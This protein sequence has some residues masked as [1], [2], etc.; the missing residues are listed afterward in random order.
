MTDLTAIAERFRPHERLA[1]HLLGRLPSH[2]DGAHGPAHLLRVWN[3]VRRIQPS[4]GGD[5]EIL[6]AATL[7][8]DAV[9]VEKDAPDRADA[10]RRAA[11]VATATLREMGW[12]TD[13]AER[14]AHAVA[15][16]SFSAGIVAETLEARILQDAD[17]LD[18]MGAVGIARC[19]YTAGRLRSSLHDVADPGGADRPLDDRRFA[20]DHFATKLLALADRLTTETGRQLGVERHAAM[21]AFVAR[22]LG[23]LE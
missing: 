22:F 18:A 5:T 13:R 2:D 3:L 19:F 11:A 20:L 8:H 12:P 9:A 4:E 21:Q 1:A 10:S 6:A 15:A 7:L 17:R 14:V 23:E 16:H